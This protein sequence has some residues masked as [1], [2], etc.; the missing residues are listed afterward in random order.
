MA[1]EIERHNPD[2]LVLQDARNVA[3]DDAPEEAL[4]IFGDR[5]QSLKLT[6]WK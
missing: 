4:P 2:I 5:W 3:H 6:S 1:R